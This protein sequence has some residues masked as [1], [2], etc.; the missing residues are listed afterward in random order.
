M[1]IHLSPIGVHIQVKNLSRAA[2]IGKMRAILIT[3]VAGVRGSLKAADRPQ[4]SSG[5]P[6]A[7][8]S[9]IS[10]MASR[11]SYLRKNIFHNEHKSAL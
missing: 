2:K 10:G 1:H 9:K 6:A 7:N 3:S 5:A 11:D 8:G 4:Q